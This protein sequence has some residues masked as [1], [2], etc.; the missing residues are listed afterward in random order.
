MSSQVGSGHV[1]IFPTFKGFR[2]EVNK[3]ASSAGASGG[4]QFD[5]GF[6]KATKGT[7]AAAGKTFKDSFN[8][9][10][11]GLANAALKTL[12]SDVAKSSA[13]V[14]ASRLKE[15]D[16]A[17]K[18]RV[19]E[20]GLADARK[21][22]ASDSVQVVRAEERLE[23]SSRGL[24]GVQA[25]TR[26]ATERLS[27]S[28][29]ELAAATERA[30]NEARQAPSL[31]SRMGSSFRSAG[32]SAS[33]AFKSAFDSGIGQVF[34]GATLANAA[35]GAGVA[36]GR[37][38]QEGVAL[39][40]RTVGLAS[41]LGEALNANKVAFGREMADQLEILGRAAPKN[42]ALSR[43]AFAG[44]ATQFSAFA[45]AIRGNDVVGFVDELTTRG[46]DFASVY[47]LEAATALELFQSGLAGETEPLR[48]FGL[49]LSAAT[50]Q[51]FAYSH[52]IGVVGTE[53][54]EAQKQ[55]AR[56][57]TLME[58][59]ASVQGDATNTAGEYAG[60]QRRLNVAVEEAQVAFGSYLIPA[61]TAAATF[62]NTTLIPAL[63]GIV[64]KVGPVLAGALTEAGP[65]FE[66]LFAKAEPLITK[67][68]TAGAQDGI[69]AFVGA[70]DSIVTA[71]PDWIDAFNQADAA[72]R[73]MDSTY[74]DLVTETREGGV[75]LRGAYASN[76]AAVAAWAT[77]TGLRLGEAIRLYGGFA[78]DVVGSVGRAQAA[79]GGFTGAVAVA[80]VGLPSQLQRAGRDAFQGFVN[81][82]VSKASDVYSTAK[83]I[84]DNV[85]RTIKGA[86]DIKSPS[87]VLFALGENTAQG[88]AN[89][90]TSTTPRVQS[91]ARHMVALPSLP[92]S[93][94]SVAASLSAGAGEGSGNVY[95]DK[96]VAPDQNPVVSGR[97]IAAEFLKRKAG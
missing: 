87:R 55:Q 26:A 10:T 65:K 17:G 31:F 41:D 27:A 81:G 30:N 94:A 63:G 29:R 22:Y 68:V 96:I 25:T 36:I 77:S 52:G 23:S 58:Q 76:E 79:V 34:A 9:S 93:S 64:D 69:P 62:A 4:G 91:A 71:A 21:K 47:N 53:L 6:R 60:Q 70:M 2:S 15:Q 12:T 14:S 24:Q 46:A 8:S 74:R 20:A 39:A 37:G 56:Y 72:V 82:I 3:E 88:F 80:F 57:G 51:A 19:A 89:G 42:L 61:F 67:L 11:S 85:V 54:T 86:L 35:T 95:I 50:V 84:A 28:Q 7:G 83:S 1:A 49:D 13:Q 40:F 59:T 97:I 43:R 75:I 44:F 78:S 45:R 5:Q 66:E 48:R 73:D 90:I 38:L 16:A 92:T 18:V 32:T 33:G